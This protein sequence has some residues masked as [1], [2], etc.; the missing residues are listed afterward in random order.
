MSQEYTEALVANMVEVN[1]IETAL[2]S[3]PKIP[4]LDVE[5]EVK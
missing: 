4:G 1:A 5:V 3:V 2:A